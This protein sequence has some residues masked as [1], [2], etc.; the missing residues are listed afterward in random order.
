VTSLFCHCE[1]RKRRSNPFP[2]CHYQ[3]LFLLSLPAS[4]YFVIASLFLFCH[5][6]PK[7]R[8][9]LFLLSLPASFYFVIASR[10]RGNLSLLS[11]PA[12]FSPVIASLFLSRHC[13]PKAWQPLSSVITSLFLFCHCQPKARQSQWWGIPEN[14]L[15]VPIAGA[16]SISLGGWEK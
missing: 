11:L 6:E 2:S 8:Q 5:C 16:W 13:E 14:R 1:E 3:P 15:L 12:P 10:R 9:P 4:F 7:A